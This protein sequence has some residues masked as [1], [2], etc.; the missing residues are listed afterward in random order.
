MKSG[1][2]LGLFLLSFVLI[3]LVSAWSPDPEILLTGNSSNNVRLTQNVTLNEKTYSISLV[4]AT[5]TAAK[6]RV[7]DSS[8][9]YKES[10]I[11]EG[12][13][14]IVNGINVLI[15]SS[16]VVSNTDGWYDVLLRLPQEPNL[17]QNAVQ[18]FSDYVKFSLSSDYPKFK[19]TVSG[20]YEV[21]LISAS[22]S[23]ATIKFTNGGV[24][25]TKEISENTAV[26]VNGFRVSVMSANETNLKLSADIII[27]TPQTTIENTEETDSDENI[28]INNE[29]G[30]L[31]EQEDKDLE[32]GEEQELSESDKKK[33]IRQSCSNGCLKDEK[34]YNFGYRKSGEFCSGDNEF[35][36]QFG[37]A[38]QCENHFECESNVCVS[39][40]CVEGTLIQKILN[41]F[42][43]LFGGE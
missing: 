21:E 7:T 29:S 42:R 43:N 3:S 35:L 5:E 36:I 23:A 22:D 18:T 16:H 25:E 11:Q 34:C 20:N 2:I 24:S 32:I 38:E 17:G 19:A 4:S 15:V 10:E 13:A 28:G 8:G 26:I 1:A 12:G 40:Q 27:N 30:D 41:W 6:I 14:N 39:G 37:D 9:I 31:T 33:I